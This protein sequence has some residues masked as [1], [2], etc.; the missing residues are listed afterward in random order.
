MYYKISDIRAMWAVK[1]QAILADK[2]KLVGRKVAKKHG[3]AEG[4]VYNIWSRYGKLK[5]KKS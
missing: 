2:G 5:A 4:T 3:F 1:R